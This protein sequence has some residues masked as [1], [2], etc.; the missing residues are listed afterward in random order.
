M[1][2]V[3]YQSEL[4]TKYH[5][6]E[7]YHPIIFPFPFYPSYPLVLCWYVAISS[8][9]HLPRAWCVSYAGHRCR[10][11]TIGKTKSLRASH[12]L[13]MIEQNAVYVSSHRA[14]FFSRSFPFRSFLSFLLLH[15][16]RQS[17]IRSIGDRKR[18]EKYI[19]RLEC[20]FFFCFLLHSVGQCFC[21][22]KKMK[23]EITLWM[24]VDCTFY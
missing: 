23:I 16:C 9:V 3:R 22:Q 19:Y 18:N 6:F 2:F 24:H 17:I 20:F 21:D 12:L 8:I 14:Q 13:Y 11:V 10:F 1:V 7:I 4:V 5:H 15:I